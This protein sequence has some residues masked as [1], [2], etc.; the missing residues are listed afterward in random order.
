MCG[1]GGGPKRPARV[2]E[3]PVAPTVESTNGARLDSRRRRKATGQG[4]TS[5]VLSS[6]RG[7]NGGAT[8]QATLL[9]Q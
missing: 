6:A 8:T 5:N 3:A 7:T 4:N 2:P 9:G 1:G